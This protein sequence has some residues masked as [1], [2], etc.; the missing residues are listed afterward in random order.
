MYTDFWQLDVIKGKLSSL[1]DT[2]ILFLRLLNLDRST[3][4]GDWPYIPTIL[5]IYTSTFSKDRVD[6]NGLQF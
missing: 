3:D 4:N 2:E 6:F 1:K 5:I